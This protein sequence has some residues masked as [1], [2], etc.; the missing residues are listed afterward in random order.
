[1]A[2][3][4]V[5]LQCGD[6]AAVAGAVAA[7]AALWCWRSS[8]RATRRRRVIA[9]Q[10]ASERTARELEALERTARELEALER[11]AR[12]LET[13]VEAVEH[14][15]KNAFRSE[16]TSV[17]SEPG[18]DRA[19]HAIKRGA[20][21][22]PPLRCALE[23]TEFVLSDGA[24]IRPGGNM[25]VGFYVPLGSAEFTATMFICGAPVDHVDH[26]VFRPGTLVAPC[27]PSGTVLSGAMACNS[28]ARYRLCGEHKVLLVTAIVSDPDM[29]LLFNNTYVML[30]KTHALLMTGEV[31]RYDAAAMRRL[32]AVL[33]PR[34]RL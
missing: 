12:E 4:C 31:V 27:G 24:E 32:A 26:V 28:R 22:T 14:E 17:L 30:D 1:M 16:F 23:A 33:L 9:L 34:M 3:A 18:A 29:H 7:S 20:R 19:L 25:H 21:K 5:A 11:T 15:V 8:R 13:L 2:P 10:E 6:A